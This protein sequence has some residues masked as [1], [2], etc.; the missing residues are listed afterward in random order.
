MTLRPHGKQEV[1]L[2]TEPSWSFDDHGPAYPLSFDGSYARTERVDP[3]PC[4]AHDV[5]AVRAEL[6]HLQRVAPIP[7]PLGIFVLSHEMR[8]RTNAWCSDDRVYPSGAGT[9]NSYPISI[10]VMSGKRIPIH[11]AMTRYLVAHE[12]GHFVESFL[13][14]ERGL[15]DGFRLRERY[16]ALCRPQGSEVYGCGKWH[17]ATGEIFANDFRILIANREAEFWPHPG[18]ARPEDEL[19]VIG[20]WTKVRDELWSQRD[21]QNLCATKETA[22]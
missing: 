6:A 9:V 19:S 18:V 5:D 8:G 14:R 17:Q 7:V 16:R 10:I 22:N 13:A 15:K 2:L 20:F 3:A 4:Y 1:I 21:Q 12:Y 11:P